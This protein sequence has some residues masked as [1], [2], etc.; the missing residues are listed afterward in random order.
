[1]VRGEV[2]GKQMRCSSVCVDGICGRLRL[3]VDDEKKKRSDW[4]V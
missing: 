1:M 3:S 4:V 2:C